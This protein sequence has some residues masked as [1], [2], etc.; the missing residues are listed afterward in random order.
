[1]NI[2]MQ[3]KKIRNYELGIWGEGNETCG[4]N[5]SLSKKIGLFFAAVGFWLGGFFVGES[6]FKKIRWR[7]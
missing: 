5:E 7:T 2:P 6:L 1:M 3:Q 4:K